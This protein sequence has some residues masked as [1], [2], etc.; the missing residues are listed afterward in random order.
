MATKFGNASANSAK[1]LFE[2]N[3]NIEIRAQGTVSPEGTVL[4]GSKFHMEGGNAV[5]PV[6]IA[7]TV[8]TLVIEAHKAT[9]RA[10]K[11]VQFLGQRANATV[12][13]EERGTER[14]I[15]FEIVGSKEIVLL[16][17][18]RNTD[19]TLKLHTFVGQGWN[20]TPLPPATA[21]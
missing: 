15:G 11:N 14:L 4:T 16:D 12:Y 5:D 6:M 18:G 3:W 8:D 20:I 19:G 2:K 1:M 13:L 21:Q 17:S 10:R 7:T 9:F